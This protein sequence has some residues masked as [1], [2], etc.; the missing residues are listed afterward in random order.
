MDPRS[1][2]KNR[3]DNPNYY[4]AFKRKSNRQTKAGYSSNST[5][6]EKSVQ[7]IFLKASKK[8][9]HKLINHVDVQQPKWPYQCWAAHWWGLWSL[10]AGGGR[11]SPGVGGGPPHWAAPGPW[12][13]QCWG[14]R[15]RLSHGVRP[16]LPGGLL[17]PPT[18]TVSRHLYVAP[19]AIHRH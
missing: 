7:L 15:Q 11:R 4:N 3:K 12:W 19:R 6:G 5:A 2:R 1:V 8:A 18:N 17:G 16:C 10:L 9:K 13:R 14:W